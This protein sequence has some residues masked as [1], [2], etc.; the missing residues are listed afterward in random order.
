MVPVV[1]SQDEVLKYM[2]S[3]SNWG[4]WGTDDE[5]GTI[6]HIT[7][8]VRIAAS[9][10]V[11]DGVT[12]SC[13]RQIPRLAESDFDM[14]PLH[15]MMGGGERF[16]DKK[17]QPNEL[18]STADFFGIAPHGFSVT[19]V[20]SL[21]HVL[22]DG[23]LYNGR[24][25]DVVSTSRASTELAVDLLKD[26]V[27]SRGVL[28]DFPRLR[29]VDWLDRTD[30]IFPEDLDNAE[31]EHGVKLRTGDVLLGR[32]GAMRRRNQEGPSRKVYENRPGFHAT[33]CPWFHEREIAAIGS[34]SAQD[35]FPSGYPLM[36]APVHQIGIVAMGLWL[37][38][39]CD[40]EALAETCHRLGRYEFLFS[41]G[42]LRITG[43]TGSPVNPTAIF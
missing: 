1:P 15:Y 10:L 33:C 25:A 17:T 19:H 22:R 31:R 3:C 13:S 4:R 38:D 23:V 35:L 26:G 2:D 39:N 6:N 24:K 8:Q 21:S 36:R 28:L 40:L 27:V 14:P 7:P 9:R 42:P 29:G 43:G 18:Q 16:V 30:G 12:V 41:M 11:K 20:D 32:F 37:I 5:L 34:D